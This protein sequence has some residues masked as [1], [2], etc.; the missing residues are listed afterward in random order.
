MMK[1]TLLK[2]LFRG[3]L[4]LMLLTGAGCTD[5]D[6]DEKAPHNDDETEITLGSE[7]ELKEWMFDY[8]KEN[9]LW[10]DAVKQVT[11]DYALGYE[12]FLERILLDVAAQDDVNHDDGYWE[13]G[14]R[15][16]F[17]SMIERYKVETEDAA[18]TTR[19]LRETA[20]DAGFVMLYYM[21]RDQTWTD[22]LFQVGGV[23][24][25]SPAGKAGLRRG[26]CIEKIDGK[27]FGASQIDEMYDRI[28]APEG[29]VTL[30]LSGTAEQP[31]REITY[32]LE[33]YE[34]NPVWK[35]AV[36]TTKGG[37]RVG[38]LCYNTFNLYYDDALLDAF[39][40]FREA[41]VEELILDLRYN[42]GGHVASS[43]LMGTAV[44]GNA[45]KDKVFMR[46]IYN[47]DRQ[48]AGESGDLFRIGN[49]DFG[50]GSYEQIASA[51]D[52]S[53]GLPRIY[54]LCSEATAS[55]SEL[56]ING[57]RG[58]G[59]EVRLIGV[60]T[61]GKNVGMERSFRILDGYEYDFSPITFY[62]E[63]AQGSADYGE[64][65]T[66]DLEAPET[67]FA[68]ADWGSPDDGLTALALEWIDSGQKPVVKTRSAA[69]PR[70]HALPTP[71]RRLQGSIVELNPGSR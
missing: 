2:E 48:A 33:P 8:M 71:G 32:H 10:N 38:Y 68:L 17:Y 61:N 5:P 29:D 4:L 28:I 34:D 54:L 51:L 1:N 46:E 23:S 36:L 53:L 35:S 63:N 44:A 20:E 18:A 58:L 26:D 37:R 9:Y 11:P 55:A 60:R 6:S 12:A 16:S 49:T 7:Q 59:I 62:A 65:F 30:T 43:L 70:L 52:V 67:D 3:A 14:T 22:C 56:L 64:G 15:L 69:A 57:L 13:N 41:G 19:G 45:Q 31:A 21:Y 40:M 25:F 39:A 66:P 24:P 47:A 27:T 42:S 50:S